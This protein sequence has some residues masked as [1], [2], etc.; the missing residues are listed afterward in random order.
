MEAFNVGVLHGFLGLNMN[1]LD[2]PIHSPSE[3]MP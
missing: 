3:K 2:P 1:E